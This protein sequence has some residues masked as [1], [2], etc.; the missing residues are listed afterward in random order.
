MVLLQ[1]PNKKHISPLHV[2]ILC[3][4]VC[5]CWSF[6]YVLRWHTFYCAC[7][8]VVQV[9]QKAILRK[10]VSLVQ[11]FLLW[12]LYIRHL[13]SCEGKMLCHERC[14]ADESGVLVTL[15]DGSYVTNYTQLFCPPP[16]QSLSRQASTVHVWHSTLIR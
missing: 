15:P 2:D 16:Q 3:C 6:L 10:V 4:I 1:L 8:A 5:K 12:M 9:I 14:I 13:A 11:M 7:N